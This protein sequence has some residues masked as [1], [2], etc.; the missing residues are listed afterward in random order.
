LKDK[1]ASKFKRGPIKKSADYSPEIDEM[2][3]AA[4]FKDIKHNEAVGI[5]FKYKHCCIHDASFSS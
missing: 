4:A 1:R 2:E 3:N 5:D